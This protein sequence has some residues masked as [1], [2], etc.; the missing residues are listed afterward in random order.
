MSEQNIK[1]SV[2]IPSYNEERRIGATLDQFIEYLNQQ[3]Y[4]WEIL[5]VDDGSTDNMTSILQDKYLGDEEETPVRLISYPKNRGKGYAMRVGVAES[6]GEFALVSDADASTPLDDIE[7]FWPRFDA[8][9]DIVIGSRA[10]P[11][12]DVQIRQPLYRQSMGRIFNLLLR[13]LRLTRF[14]DTQCG[15]K[16]IRMTCV[17]T[18]F[19]RMTMDGFGADCEMLYI[20][21][22]FGYTVEEV[23]VRWLNSIDTRVHP[24]FDSFDMFIEV[25][26]VRFRSLMGKYH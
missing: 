25:V 1:L 19:S 14:K 16:V 23:P 22:K 3:D 5:V 4:S 13:F 20:A 26:S 6:K 11:Q 10:M 24:I 15:F 12:S 2:I 7:K 21:E 8:G 18:V 9:A 17:E